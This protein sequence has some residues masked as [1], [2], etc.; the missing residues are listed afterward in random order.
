MAV[1]TLQTGAK[2]WLPWGRFFFLFTEREE[3][4]LT[5]HRNKEV[6]LGYRQRGCFSSDDM[7]RHKDTHPNADIRSRVC[8]LQFAE[9]FTHVLEGE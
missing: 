3:N 5:N 6:Y 8:S 9:K 1:G 7:R 4:A 2:I